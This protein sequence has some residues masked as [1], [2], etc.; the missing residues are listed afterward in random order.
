M[1]L[2]MNMRLMVGLA[3]LAASVACGGPELG[4]DVSQDDPSVSWEEFSSRAVREPWEGGKLIV[5]GDIALPDEAALRAY[6]ESNVT[7]EG[8]LS[9]NRIFRTDDLWD[10]PGRFRLT[11]CVSDAFGWQKPLVV[12]TMA[13]ATASWH[14]T[15]GVRFEYLPAHDGNCDQ[16]NNAVT[17]DVRPVSTSL[18]FARAFFPSEGRATRNL[19]IAPEA[20]TTTSGGRDLEGI[21]RHELGHA[22]GFRHEHI[23]LSSSCTSETTA[24]ARQVTPYD[25]MSVMHYPQCRPWG[26]GGYRQSDLDYVGG[27]ELYGL[28]P[29]QIMASTS[30]L[31]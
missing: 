3:S 9:V 19:L 7:G 4:I 24:Y 16:N 30:S 14:D 23:W 1:N 11:Y 31:L 17:F 28:A 29:G 2:R 6:Y 12:L 15:I 10:H 18:Y 22:L 8:A 21:L 27:I 13:S 26:G 25:V 5:D 20:F